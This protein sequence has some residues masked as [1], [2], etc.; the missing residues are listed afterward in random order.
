[1]A[2]ATFLHHRLNKMKHCLVIGWPKLVSYRIMYL[3]LT[4]I[5]L[6]SLHA[7][8][9]KL[10]HIIKMNLFWHSLT[11]VLVIL[12]F[13]ELYLI[14]CDNV[15]NVEGVWINLSLTVYFED[16]YTTFYTRFVFVFMSLLSFFL[17]KL[18]ALNPEWVM[19]GCVFAVIFTADPRGAMNDVVV[20]SEIILHCA[21]L[22][23]ENR[24][25]QCCQRPSPTNN[26]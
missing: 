4:A 15:R 12:P 18:C 6:N 22:G 9:S 3:H 20:H 23:G 7:F 8:L 1:M 21:G 5:Q 25:H 16:R 13:S 11:W 26:T 24:I 17:E 2:N 14:N 19:K 10:S